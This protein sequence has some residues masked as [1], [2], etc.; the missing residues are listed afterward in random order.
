MG[1]RKLTIDGKE[2][3]YIIG[4]KFTKI[5][6]PDKKSVVIGNEKIGVLM[7]KVIFMDWVYDPEIGDE[8]CVECMDNDNLNYA[9]KPSHIRQWILGAT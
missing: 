8:I 7:G 1:Y 5:K 6:I 9:V 4:K 2:Y 3:E